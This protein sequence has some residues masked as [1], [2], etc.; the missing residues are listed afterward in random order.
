MSLLAWGAGEGVRYASCDEAHF[1]RKKGRDTKDCLRHILSH[2]GL[3]RH[4]MGGDLRWRGR[5]ANVG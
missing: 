3:D 4:S 2:L 1:K 5:G